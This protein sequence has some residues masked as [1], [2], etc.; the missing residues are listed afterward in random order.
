MGDF[1]QDSRRGDQY[2]RS[3]DRSRS[4]HY[5]E[6]TS[7]RVDYDPNR[8]REENRTHRR[9]KHLKSVVDFDRRKD[10]ARYSREQD[11]MSH[12]HH[13]PRREGRD[14]YPDDSTRRRD[15]RSDERSQRPRSHQYEREG[16]VRRRGSDDE[17]SEAVGSGAVG[18][19]IEDL[20]KEIQESTT[21]SSSD[22][23][24]CTV[25]LIPYFF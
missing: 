5:R 24:V 20:I 18:G 17:E 13:P 22:E 25:L 3:G 14:R 12:R 2:S 8:A 1:T 4:K 15:N 23:Q 16:G 9:E 10:N 6:H 7:R 21:D 11:S 19:R